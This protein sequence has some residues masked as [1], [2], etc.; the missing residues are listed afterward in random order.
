LFAR[1]ECVS[2]PRWTAPIVMLADV[3]VF[4]RLET[5]ATPGKIQ[6]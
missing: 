1:D 3:A 2:S 6:L 4:A 5:S